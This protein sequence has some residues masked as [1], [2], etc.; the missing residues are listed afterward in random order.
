[1]N[2]WKHLLPVATKDLFFLLL[3]LAALSP[4]SAATPDE[5]PASPASCQVSYQL[6]ADGPLPRTYCVTLAVVAPKNPDWIISQFVAGAPRTVT[7]E[8]Q[9]HFTETWDGLDDNFMPVPP[10]SY[11]VRGIYMPARK[12]EVDGEYHSVTPRFA[13]GASAFMPGLDQAQKPEPFGGDPC[14]QPLGDVDVGPNGLAV[15]Y[16]VYLEN[17]LN[18]PIIDLKKPLGPGQFVRA[19]G[20]GGAA[21]GSATATDGETVWSF[22]T[23]G[24]PKFVYRADA[25]PFGTGAGQR[26]NV[27]RPDGWVKGM[28]A[29]HDP[30]LAKSFV[31]VAQGG[32][33]LEINE[34]P[35]FVESDKELVDKITVHDGQSGAV[36]AELPVRRPRGLTA[37]YGTLYVLHGTEGGGCAVSA[38]RL[39]AGKPGSP[40][41]VLFTLP[42]TI[43]PTDVE[44]DSHG[45]L[46][47]SDSAANKVYQMDRSGKILHTLG[48]LDRQKPGSYDPLSFIAPGKL[49]TWTDP[50]GADRL[51]VVEHGGPNRVSEWSADGQLLREFLS[52]Q[53]KAND[54]YAI[55]P[56]RPEHAYVPGHQGW[57]TRFRVDYAT[58]AWTVDAVWPEI[59]TDPEAPGFD[60]PQCINF[61]GHKYLVCAKSYSV[62]R[63]EGDRWLLSAAIIR[64]GEGNKRHYFLWHDLNGDGRVQ[65]DEYRNNPVELPGWVLRYHGEQWLDDLSLVAINQGGRDVWR[66]APEGFDPLGNPIFK[67]WKKLLTD[68]V[69]EA[70]AEG[71]ADAVH[72]GNELDTRFSSDWAMVDGLPQEG[73]YVQAR[74]GYSFSANQ[75]AQVKVSRYVPDGQGG[76]R[77]KWRTGRATLQGIARPGEIYG[78]LHLHRPIN[79]L[80]SIVDQSRCGVLLYTEDG[81]YVDTLFPDGRRFRPEIAGLYAQPGEFFAGSIVPNAASGKIYIAMGKYTPV[82][83]EAQ[84]WT[85]RQNPARPLAGLPETV[86]IAASQIADPPEIALSVRGGAGAA[87]V[88]RFAPALGGAVLD[89]SMAGWDSCAPIEFQADKDQTVEV[90]CQYD[91]EHLYLRWHARLAGR[92]QP[93]PLEPIERI[94]THDRLADTLS[95]YVQ[96]DPAAKPGGPAEGRPGDLRIVLGIF[97]DGDSLRPVALG[98]YPHAP[99]AD[100]AKPQVYSTPTGKAAFG[101]V[102]PLGNAKLVHAM[103]PDG[104]GFVLTAAI[105]RTAI[106]PL[107]P[108]A[109]GLHTRVNFSA[110]FA[111]HNKFWWANSDGSASRETYDE[112]TEARLYPG[113]WAPAQFQGLDQGVLVRNW[114]ICGPWGGPGAEHFHYDPNLPGEKERVRAFCDAATY[115]PDD[116]VVD[117]EAVFRGPLH[118]GYWPDPGAVRWKNATTAD[119]DT[120]LT[121]GGGAQVWYAAT[122]IHVPEEMELEFQFQGHPMTPLRF[123]LNGRQVLSGE[124]LGQRIIR[125]ASRNLTLRRGWNQVMLRGYCVGYSPSRAGLVLAGP[126]EKLWSLRLSA[127]PP[128]AAR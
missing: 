102:A 76:Y 93:Q 50:E 37:R 118:R 4:A 65:E 43:D 52:L 73:F 87:R 90:R 115:P 1:M 54:G 14:G 85:L 125:T 59:G 103:D 28:A 60:H 92:F 81:L 19:F 49:A 51:L 17:G 95:F 123:F 119:L 122:W 106:P 44:A 27:Y 15:F 9:G 12:W 82:V 121:L 72:G 68:P 79:G 100:Q 128:S 64:K 47:V 7:A 25:K 83:Y 40:L 67:S 23:D 2:Y 74:G 16:Y 33:I 111:G 26:R 84:G 53:T 113:S 22:S 75:G 78:A 11:A 66:L 94:F 69:F 107:P 126:P 110:T 120:R 89:G 13:G 71:K 58:G 117:P 127:M 124:I 96:G 42:A 39:A 116:G 105:P 20:S 99:A 29:W 34:W 55:D 10:G 77:L 6:P 36:L 24:G 70:R 18:N 5:S 31:Y 109:G 21:G 35:K 56:E 112:P 80:L 114:L 86:T 41:Q 104:K 57:L 62:Y 46:Y 45:R 98:M 97:K 108:L 91:P 48:R 88:A 8:N 30:A 61:G 101:H 32:K 38:A 63:Q 3:C